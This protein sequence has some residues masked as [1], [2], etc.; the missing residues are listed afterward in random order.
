MHKISS[1]YKP[2]FTSV[3]KRKDL[4]V[5]SFKSSSNFNSK[6]SPTFQKFIPFHVTLMGSSKISKST[7]NH[8]NENMY[9][10]DFKNYFDA[11]LQILLN[12]AKHHEAANFIRHVLSGVLSADEK[13]I[14][15][16][17]DFLIINLQNELLVDNI[18]N[19]LDILIY[20]INDI[21]GSHCKKALFGIFRNSLDQLLLNSK[22]TKDKITAIENF[23]G[24]YENSLHLKHYFYSNVALKAIKI[25][26]FH[27]FHYLNLSLLS[28][29]SATKSMKVLLKNNR[30]SSA[31]DIA[32]SCKEIN[33]TIL[34]ELYSKVVNIKYDKYLS[35]SKFID[36]ELWLRNNGYINNEKLHKFANKPYEDDMWNDIN[37]M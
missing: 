33:K 36:F 19:Y 14:E 7:I 6:D 35:E 29:D 25:N 9:D 11:V 22:N 5:T 18:E 2:I 26:H 37:D 34:L 30:F 28:E 31:I 4:L 1:V 12:N 21:Q 23:L 16:I 20:L 8:S 32:K 13:T 3:S 27:V 17:K 24:S 15:C 10:F